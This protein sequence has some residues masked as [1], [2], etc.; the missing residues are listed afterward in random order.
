MEIGDTLTVQTLTRDAALL[1]ASPLDA[2]TEHAAT[3]ALLARY[4][5]A[6]EE[7]RT[8]GRRWYA[9]AR[10]ACREIAQEFGRPLSQVAAVFAITSADASLAANLRWTRECCAGLRR[11]G[12]YPNAQAAKVA[13]ALSSRRPGRFVSGAKV[14]PFYRAI[15]GDDSALVVDRWAAFAAGAAKAAPVGRTRA[16]LEGAYARAAEARGETPSAFQAVVWIAC[17]EDAETS[18]GR[19]VRHADIGEVRAATC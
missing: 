18:D 14:A 15:M 8:R 12:R 2:L 13:G 19:R 11:G 17:R 16:L 4:D 6:T 3:V 5:G 9:E 7:Q 1:A 10:A